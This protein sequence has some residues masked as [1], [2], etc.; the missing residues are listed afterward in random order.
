VELFFWIFWKPK[1]VELEAKNLWKIPKEKE[2]IIAERI[3]LPRHQERARADANS[4]RAEAAEKDEVSHDFRAFQQVV[5]EGI[6]EKK[7]EG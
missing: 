7:L 5:S 4:T 2:T 1:L 6:R 3:I